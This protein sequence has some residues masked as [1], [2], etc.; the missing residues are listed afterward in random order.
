MAT[1]QQIATLKLTAKLMADMVKEVKAVAADSLVAEAP[2]EEEVDLAG[3]TV[4]GTPVMEE[5]EAE[6]MEAGL[7]LISKAPATTVGSQ[8]TR[9]KIVERKLQQKEPALQQKEKLP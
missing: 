4:E 1:R 3:A 9:F 2:E 7:D 6:E 8:A 5:L